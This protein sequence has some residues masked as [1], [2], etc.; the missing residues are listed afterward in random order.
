M[1]GNLQSERTVRAPSD[2]ELLRAVRGGDD[3]AYGQ[4]YARHADAALRLAKRM[5]R[6]TPISA[7]DAVSD[8]FLSVLTTIRGGG[9]PGESF[10][11]YLY[12][13]VRNGIMATR[14]RDAPL[15]SVDAPE[16]FETPEAPQDPVVTA[17]ETGVVDRA[18]SSLP[19]RWQAVLW[20]HEIEGM[21][22]GAIAPLLGLGANAT[23]AL[24]VRAREGLREAYLSAHVTAAGRPECRWTAERM[25]SDARG[26]LSRRD[27]RRFDTH[28]ADCADC[29]TMAAEV[30][31]VS[32]GL[33]VIVAPLI[34]GGGLAGWLSQ[35]AFGSPGGPSAAG[36]VVTPRAAM[37]IGAGSTVALVGAVALMVVLGL[38]QGGA[39]PQ[40]GQAPA[41]AA[42]SQQPV[43]EP[44][45][46]PSST[47][48]A[49]VADPPSATGG[50]RVPTRR[51]QVL[52]EPSAPGPVVV[53]STPWAGTQ[54]LI[55]GGAVIVDAARSE[56][57]LAA[58]VRAA[59]IT[60]VSNQTLTRDLV[61]LD[62]PGGQFALNADTVETL[63]LPDGTVRYVSTVD[64]T[65]MVRAIG[66]GTWTLA[67]EFP[68]VD[69]QLAVTTEGDEVVGVMFDGP[70][71]LPAGAKV[72]IPL[73]RTGTGTVT[74]GTIS[75]ASPV[76]FV[77]DG[78][79]NL[80]AEEPVVIRRVIVLFDD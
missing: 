20:Y 25:G 60:W 28:L 19:E 27:R 41:E 11:A 38:G 36:P 80:I 75:G 5:T 8:A 61:I 79:L 22:P 53:P 58:P 74:V 3:D 64:A 33:R 26:S 55:R 18:F 6:G 73:P 30:K 57:Q 68:V 69:W 17:Y 71:E 4:L 34:L 21:K 76:A 23:S 51:P 2:D 7:E 24:L 29:R 66:A 77:R 16:D 56:L 32:R 31:E 9:G 63:D 49:P 35:Q 48:P 1:P 47:D 39:A 10:R 67:D 70:V 15:L 78:V 59:E 54:T 13:V 43:A 65:E 37:F 44:A 42:P 62:T 40:G 12:T 46:E 14:Q 52:P 45:P 50:P 72:A